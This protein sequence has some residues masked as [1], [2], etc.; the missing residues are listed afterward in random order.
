MP[1][2]VSV[3]TAALR[4]DQKHTVYWRI[5]P[6]EVSQGPLRWQL[7]DQVVEKQIAVSDKPDRLQQVSVRRP[8]TDWLQ[9]LLHPGEA[10]FGPNALVAAIAVHHPKQ[11]TPIFGI[12]VPW[13]A[14]FFIVSI[15]GALLAKPWLKVQF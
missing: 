1:G 10:A 9:R 8:G 13:W 3:E 14:T 6:G 2:G 11:T 15:A 4:D 5:R 12:H 7:G